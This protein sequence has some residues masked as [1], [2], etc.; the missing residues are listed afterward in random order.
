MK[1]IEIKLRCWDTGINFMYYDADCYNIYNEC[2]NGLHSGYEDK[3]G[4]WHQNKIMQY[5]GLN[6][7]N[8]VEIYNGDILGHEDTFFEVIYK[9]A[10]YQLYSISHNSYRLL[11]SLNNYMCVVG[12]IYENPELLEKL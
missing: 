7:K 9:D 8:D 11:S 10:S 4:V 5:S 1:M 6:D 12:N 2:D 3:Y